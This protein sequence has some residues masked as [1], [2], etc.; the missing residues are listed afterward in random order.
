L[1][2]E[3]YIQAQAARYVRQWRSP[4]IE[5]D[6][7]VQEGHLAA[8]IHVEQALAHETP[9]PYLRKIIV[10]AIAQYCYDYITPIRKPRQ[11]KGEFSSIPVVSLDTLLTQESHTTYLDLLPLSAMSARPARKWDYSRL[12]GAIEQLPW[13]QRDVI[14]RHFGFEGPSETLY[15][16]SR[17]LQSPSARRRATKAYIYKKKALARLRKHLT[18]YTGL[19]VDQVDTAN[20]EEASA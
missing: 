7:L 11:R 1:S 19:V 5:Y 13:R 18:Q 2:F 20:T 12:Y 3:S 9:Y 15:M 4:R 17:S 6:D 10:K 14:M 8:L 16:I